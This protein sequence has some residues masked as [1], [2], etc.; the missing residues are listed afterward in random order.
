MAGGSAFAG[1]IIQGAGVD[2]A[3]LAAGGIGLV[4]AAFG[5]LRLPAHQQTTR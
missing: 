1:M 5:A 2:A 4:G 3:F